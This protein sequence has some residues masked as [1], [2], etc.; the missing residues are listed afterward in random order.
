MK[1]LFYCGLLLMIGSAQAG[2]SPACDGPGETKVSWPQ[3]SPIWEFCYLGPSQSSAARGSS[4]EIRD[5]YLDGNLVLERAHLPMLFANYTSGTCY[6]DW[7]DTESNFLQS[8]LTL[9]TPRPAITTCDASVSETLPVGN[10]PFQDVS[11]GGSGN[12]GS[13]ADCFSGVDV[14][15][16]DDRVLLTTNHSAAW[17]KYTA[18]FTFHADGRIEPRFGF[19]NSD[20]TFSG[21]THWHHGYW[22]LN[23]D[24]DGSDNDQIFQGDTLMTNEFSGQRDMTGGPGGSELTWSI[25]DSVTNRGYRVVPT[26][27]DYL[28]DTDPSSDGYHVVDVM[29][30]RYKLVLGN[31]IP[32]YS[33]TPGN[34]SLGNCSMDD[35]ALVDGE[36]LVGEDVVFWY[37]TAVTDLANMGMVCKSGGPIFEPIGEWNIG[38]LFEDGFE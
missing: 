6:R 25:I 5:A 31:T 19:G 23:F 1:N 10:C 35:G 32:E 9:P 11:V 4:L 15:I 13:G 3:G 7:K 37:R 2:T 8:D 36:S 12:V 24:I 30:T 29:A 26:R 33:D 14:E 21:T 34:N 16:Y 38:E 22:R 27:E 17:Y 20:G 28:T 18:R